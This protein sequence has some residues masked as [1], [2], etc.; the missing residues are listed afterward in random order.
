MKH[1]Y[2]LAACAALALAP[3]SQSALALGTAATD[4]VVG[5]D[6]EFFFS[7]ASASD[8][9][10]KQFMKND[11]CQAGTYDIYNDTQTSTPGNNF[12]AISCTTVAGAP[13][14]AGLQG[15]DIILYKRNKIGSIYGV[16]PVALNSYVEFMNIKS[17]RGSGACTLT[18]TANTWNCTVAA[19]GSPFRDLPRHATNADECDYQTA[20]PA[21]PVVPAANLDTLCRRPTMGMADVEAE[22][23]QLNNLPNLPGDNFRKL[24]GAELGAVT[25][26]RVIGQIFGVAVSDSVFTALQAAQGIAVGAPATDGSNWP[27]L[28]KSTVR[29]IVGGA[30]A[31]WTAAVAGASFT[32]TGLAVCRR[33]QG[34]GSQA[35]SNMFFLNYPCDTTSGFTPKQDNTASNP[36]A[37][38]VWVKENLSTGAVKNCLNDA[39]TGGTNAQSGVPRGGIGVISFNGLPGATDKWRF[40]K[41]DGVLPSMDNA[42]RGAYEFWTESQIGYNS[43][44]ATANELAFAP[45]IIGEI[46]KPTRITSAGANGIGAMSFN[47]GVG[48]WD[49]GTNNQVPATATLLTLTNPVF[50]GKHGT[51][52]SGYPTS[53]SPLSCRPILNSADSAVNA[54]N[55]VQ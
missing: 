12:W 34:S 39:D 38:A 49:N 47:T 25:R 5:T 54:P 29:Q 2:R 33:E 44:N 24:T 7:G 19:T 37:T 40:V 1:M 16:F 26:T 53:G 52:A 30:A 20:A 43:A 4:L 48:T 21:N 10:I 6:R 45:A 28:S 18:A 17:N 9:A 36:A 41:I 15:V 51:A 31:T 8:S 23:F 22:M 3:L 32:N 35:T 55:R 46:S 13:A 11:F 27:T 50:G 42:I 14:P